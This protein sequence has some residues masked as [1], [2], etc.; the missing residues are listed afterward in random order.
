MQRSEIERLQ[1]SSSL[2]FVLPDGF[3]QEADE[4][5]RRRRISRCFRRDLGLNIELKVSSRGESEHLAESGNAGA[6][7][8][9]LLRI[10]RVLVAAIV[11]L[12]FS[13]G[14]L[15][16]RDMRLGPFAK[17]IV[18]D[19]IVR[20]DKD[21]VFGDG[22]V[23]FKDIG[24][25]GDGV[26]KGGKSAFGEHGAGSAVAVDQNTRVRCDGASCGEQQSKS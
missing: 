11:L 19:G 9:L 23:E 17:D 16:Y 18:D 2:Q 7:N 15:P 3:K 26:L 25:G 24:S 8:C 22:K 6:W 20:D 5:V 13:Q 4:L 10:N 21:V 14:K 12:H 1:N